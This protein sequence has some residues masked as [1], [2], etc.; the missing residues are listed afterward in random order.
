MAEWIYLLGW[1]AVPIAAI[2]LS[3]WWHERQNHAVLDGWL[4]E[5]HDAYIQLA[6]QNARLRAELHRDDRERA[7]LAYAMFDAAY[8]E[9]EI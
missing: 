8:S 4:R 6:T 9:G 7:D 1:I 5:A 3:G 2:A